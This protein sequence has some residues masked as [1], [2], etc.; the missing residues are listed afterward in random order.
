MSSI[1]S[2]NTKPEEIVRK[3]LFSK[4]MRYRK[5]DRRFPGCPDIVLLKYKSMVFVH[6]CFWHMHQ[7]CKNFSWP[8]TNS[9]FWR[10]KLEK[11]HKR[12]LENKVKLEQNGWCVFEIWE[13]ELSKGK[14]NETL[15]KLY[16]Q[17]IEHN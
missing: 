10:D 15:D 11:N 2:S 4:G 5:N 14:R 16:S 6:G 8:D 1:H 13:C 3:H 17:I 7:E 9:Q 12:D